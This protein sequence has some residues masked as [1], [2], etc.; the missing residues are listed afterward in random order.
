MRLHW[1]LGKTPRRIACASDVPLRM[2][3]WNGSLILQWRT[4]SRISACSD[5]RW[6]GYATNADYRNKRYVSHIKM[7]SLF[8]KRFYDTHERI[9]VG[10]LP[11]LMGKGKMMPLYKVYARNEQKKRNHQRIQGPQ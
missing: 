2:V 5:L 6:N 7:K 8:H 3:C 9:K 10:S 11:Q 4:P 1:P